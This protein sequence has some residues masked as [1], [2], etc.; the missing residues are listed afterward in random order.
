MLLKV[1]VPP[2]D[3]AF[4]GGY[5]VKWHMDEGDPIALGDALCDVAVDEFIALQ[6]TKRA[7]LLGSTVRRHQRKVRDGYDVREG[8]GLVHVRLTCAE[9]GAR[10][11]KIIVAEG[12]RVVIG[13]LVAVLTDGD[14][15]DDMH[16]DSLTRA[17]EARIVVNMPDA[18]DLGID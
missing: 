17:A 9:D 12:E 8:R 16:S 18:T 4:R 3:A 11:G 10:L 6:R 14:E 5:L 1:L 2:S 7:A 13:Q 15:V